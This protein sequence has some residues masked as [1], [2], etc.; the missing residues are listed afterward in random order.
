MSRDNLTE[1]DPMSPP[2]EVDVP[3]GDD[4][5][6]L[7]I[8]PEQETRVPVAVSPDET[9]VWAPLA[10]HRVD[11]IVDGDA[12]PMTPVGQGWWCAQT[13]VEPGCRYGYSL[14]SGPVR[15][16]PRTR[17]LP[18][19]PHALGEVFDPHLCDWT[20]QD[21]AGVELAGSV[22]YEMH[23]GTFTAE[24]TFDAA[25]TRLDH[26]V[27]LGVDVIEL[28]PVAA[29]PGRHG[30]GYDGVAPWAVHEPYGGPAGLQR[31]VDAAHRR[32]LG[33]CLDVVYNHLGPD[34]A[35]LHTYGPYFTDRHETPWGQALNLDGPDSDA[36]REFIV[37]NAV[38]WLRDFHVDGLRLDAV[39]EL[40]DERAVTLLEEVSAQVRALRAELGRPVWVV[41]ESDRNDPRTVISTEQGG[42]GLDGQWADDV[43]HGLHVALTGEKQGY[44]ADFAAPGALAEVLRTPF[45]HADTWSSFRGRRHGRPV[46]PGV[47]GSRFVVFLQNHDQIGNRCVGDRLSETLSTRR[48]Q[49]GAA[50]LLTGPYTPMVFMGEEWGASTPWQYFTDHVDPALAD[51][52]S[53][54]RRRE[55]ATHGWDPDRVPDPQDPVTRGRSILDWGE[56]D[57]GEHRVLLRWYRALIALRRSRA[58]LRADDLSAVQVRH[59]E[60]SGLVVVHR[61]RHRVAVNLGA[62]SVDADLEM[63]ST[64]GMVVL[65][66]TDP[67]V[68]LTEEGLVT[69]APDGVVIVGPSSAS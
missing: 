3:V 34:G 19:G 58:D 16:G 64:R 33:V 17:R 6:A 40:H 29:F 63:E 67:T 41:A 61:G 15:P 57:E 10:Q 62:H 35:V 49:C 24:G 47:P 26:L 25:I 22:L 45:F 2:G 52:V 65:L 54:G 14:D 9:L 60:D 20:D 8:V 12:R 50:L 43:H 1:P 66:A 4:S 27:D 44:Y 11:L 23:V 68:T 7:G 37:D 30:W 31:F 59:D 55:F 46:P 42:V 56:V 38:S 18:D 39:H 13:V 53:Q 48:L 28:M 69:L 5:E 51:A 36:V 21:W 32:G